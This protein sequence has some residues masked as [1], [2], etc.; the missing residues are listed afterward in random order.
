M[1]GVE[2]G[3]PCSYVRRCAEGLSAERAFHGAL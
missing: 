3:W 2:Q 1:T